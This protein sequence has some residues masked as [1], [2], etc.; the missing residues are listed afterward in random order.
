MTVGPV[1]AEEHAELTALGFAALA[2][3]SRSGAM[4][5]TGDA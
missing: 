1:S 2:L 4:L 3:N 5:A